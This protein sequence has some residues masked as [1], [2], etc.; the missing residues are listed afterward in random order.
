M[1]RAAPVLLAA[2]AWLL[3]PAEAPGWEIVRGR[4]IAQDP[5]GP[6][7]AGET[8]L[9][10]DDIDLRAGAGDDLFAFGTSL[11]LGGAFGN[12]VWAAGDRVTFDGTCEDHARLL[13][14]VVLV[15]GAVAR[16]LSAGGGTVKIGPGAR[17]GADAWIA[18]ED[19]IVEGAITGNLRV[20]AR[21]ATLAGTVEGNVEV[22]CNDLV[23]L[24]KTVIGG[25]LSYLTANPVALDDRVRLGGRLLRL[26]APPA[27]R[28]A[29][30]ALAVQ[31][32]LYLA[33]LLSC[34]AFVGLLPRYTGEA[35]RCLRR[36]PWRAGLAGA[37]A[38]GFVPLLVVAGLVT[39]VGLPAAFALG[40]AYALVAWFSQAVAG[41]L[42]G[43]LLMRRSGPQS[44]GSTAAALGIG[45]LPL[46]LLGLAPGLGGPVAFGVVVLGGGALTL[47]AVRREYP[48]TLPPPAPAPPTA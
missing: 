1:R 9:V 25:D 31:A 20:T 28:D 7:Y 19:V 27:R 45:L 10:G 5:A 44:F 37:L 35:V 24:P 47:A 41:I 6:P 16:G 48:R 23:V 40:A 43:A 21:S 36:E 15:D 3:A 30:P 22:V 46:Y 4:R 2:L 14:K 12:D 42:V 34:L 17:L 18:G 29:T 26:P 13:G 32:F 38:F 8:L 33:A 11:R 39:L